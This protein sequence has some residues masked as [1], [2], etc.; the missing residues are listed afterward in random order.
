[1]QN[2]R[3]ARFHYAIGQEISFSFFL[4][5]VSS[6]LRCAECQRWLGGAG[7]LPIVRSSQ[8]II[9]HLLSRD[10]MGIMEWDNSCIWPEHRLFDELVRPVRILWIEC[11]EERHV[12][13]LRVCPT[14]LEGRVPEWKVFQFPNLPD[15]I[16][17]DIFVLV[18][19]AFPP[20]HDAAWVCVGDTF[21]CTSL[22]HAPKPAFGM[23]AILIHVDDALNLG[24]IEEEA[25]DWSIATCHKCFG[26]A[27]NVETLH[28]TLAQKAPSEE[29]DIG[30]RVVGIEISYLKSESWVSWSR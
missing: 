26:E 6:A 24:V 25:V 11:A 9:R 1:M 20:L 29:L 17:L 4:Y 21:V 30:I 8:V 2:D 13:R 3:L 18:N 16:F 15:A 12:I 23:D 10:G 27:A 22:H 14:L 19:A 7:I 28:P 5:F